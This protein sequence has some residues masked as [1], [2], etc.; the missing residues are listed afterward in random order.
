[1]RALALLY[2]SEEVEGEGDR[3]KVLRS[4]RCL[5]SV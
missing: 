2:R 1:M 3:T 4:D 5:E